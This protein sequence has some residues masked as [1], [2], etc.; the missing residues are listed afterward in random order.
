MTPAYFGE[1]LLPDHLTVTVSLGVGSKAIT[2][3]IISLQPKHHGYRNVCYTIPFLSFVVFLL[4]VPRV[5]GV[6]HD[7][8]PPKHLAHFIPAN[9]IGP[10]HC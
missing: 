2:S 9:V 10:L 4:F 1:I 8:G 3:H 5:L 7:F 6:S